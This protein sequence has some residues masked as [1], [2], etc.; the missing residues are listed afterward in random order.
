VS[1]ASGIPEWWSSAI[2]PDNGPSGT[3]GAKPAAERT[4]LLTL[5]TYFWWALGGGVL[6]ILFGGW[7]FGSKQAA[8]FQASTAQLQLIYV[9]LGIFMVAIALGVLGLEAWTYWGGLLLSIGYGAVA[10]LEVDRWV[11]GASITL[12]VKVFIVLNILFALYNISFGLN[13][14]VRKTLRFPAFQ[15]EQFDPPLGICAIVVTLPALVVALLVNQ[16]DNHLSNP[17][18]GLVYVVGGALMIVMAFGALRL[19]TWTWVA[20]WAWEAA[21]VALSIDLIVRRVT[22]GSV[23]V[24]GLIISIVNILFA[25]TLVYYLA[26]GDVRRAFLHPH[27]KRPLFAPPMIIGGL[28]LGVLALVFYFLPSQLG[29]QAVAYTVPGLVVGLVVGLLP[30]ADPVSRLS[31]FTVGLLLAFASYM[32]RG[33]LLPYTDVWSAVVVFSLLVIITG[34]A[35][36]FRSSA[37]FVSMLLGAGIL[38]GAV[39]LQFQAAPSAYLATSALA[40][41]AILFSFGIGYMV[42]SL[43][44][45]KLVPGSRSDEA[46]EAPSGTAGAPAEAHTGQKADGAQGA[47]KEK[48]STKEKEKVAP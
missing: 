24:E 22:G 16:A 1:T 5:M 45:I 28:L 13:P 44:G 34:I 47:T 7:Y 41:V 14:A 25:A 33:G 40:L 3:G 2:S 21:L 37:W 11:N 10:V 46:P 12:E 23:S 48:E 35:A 31:G 15:G 36:L 38:Y 32:V 26:R 17:V 18:L 19:Q 43:L 9:L 42:S 29:T 8:D 4:I 20:A 6:E 27:P 39:E 30:Y